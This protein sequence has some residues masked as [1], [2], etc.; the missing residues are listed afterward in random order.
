MKNSKVLTF[1]AGFMLTGFGAWSSDAQELFRAQV[2]TTAVVTNSNGG[3]SY[4]HFGNRQILRAAADEAGL[5]NLVGLRLVYNQTAD[6][7][8]VVMGTNNVVI[9]TPLTFN[10]GVTLSKTND[11]VVERLAWVFLGTNS[12]ATGTLRATERLHFGTSNQITH[13]A[14]IGRL[15]FA[16]ADGGTNGPT[17]YS[18]TI[19]AVS[20]MGHHGHD[21]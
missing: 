3:L 19:S 14:L 16:N 10:G 11:T 15:Q 12:T 17:I 13:F 21:D 2:E 1:V 7:L 4:S 8:E 5:T 18:G 9:A 6:N 20:P